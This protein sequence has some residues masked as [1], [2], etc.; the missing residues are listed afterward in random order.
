MRQAPALTDIWQRGGPFVGANRPC[1]RV[2]VEKDFLLRTNFYNLGTWPI[3]KA[4]I[5]NFVK[6]DN[7]QIETEVPNIRTVQID[8]SLD[9]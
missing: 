9:I 6:C 4:P 7:S 2:T 5:R 3:V 1:T 8:R